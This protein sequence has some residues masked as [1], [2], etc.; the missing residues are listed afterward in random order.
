MLSP[1]NG[2][3]IKRSYTVLKMHNMDWDEED[4]RTQRG[5]SR[6]R[7]QT[8]VRGKGRR[9]DCRGALIKFSWIAAATKAISSRWPNT[10]TV[11]PSSLV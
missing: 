11:H 5:V 6:R 8:R 7:H 3:N 1:L 2:T 4:R 10:P 9:H